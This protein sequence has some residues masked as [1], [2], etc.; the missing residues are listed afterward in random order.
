MHSIE[1]ESGEIFAGID[2]ALAAIAL[3]VTSPA[4]GEC[5]LAL[6]G[7]V[8]AEARVSIYSVSGRLVATVFEGKLPEGGETVVWNG[9][10]QTGRP[11]ASGVY[12]ARV[13]SGGEM[14]TA[15]LVYIR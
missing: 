3:S 1:L 15:K 8:G 11:I 7:P 4:R 14:Q 2:D 12:F 6:S 5:V 9:L 10:D 13:E